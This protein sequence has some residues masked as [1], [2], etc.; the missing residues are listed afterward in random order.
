MLKTYYL[1]KKGEPRYHM[2]DEPFDYDRYK[3]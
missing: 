3:L 2:V 1:Q